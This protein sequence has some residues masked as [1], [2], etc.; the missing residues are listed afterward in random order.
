MVCRDR[1]ESA[2]L[3]S[4]SP[5]LRS[6]LPVLFP[7]LFSPAFLPAYTQLPS[8]HILLFFI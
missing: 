3:V 2:A 7:F 5:P 1:A 4:P 8:S 6:L